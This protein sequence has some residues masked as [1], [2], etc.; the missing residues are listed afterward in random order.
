MLIQAVGV[1]IL[2]LGGT[3]APRGG[4]RLLH[5]WNTNARAFGHAAAEAVSESRQHGLP[6]GRHAHFIPGREGSL[7]NS[8][9]ADSR[10][11]TT[12]SDFPCHAARH[13]RENDD[14][15]EG[16]ARYPGYTYP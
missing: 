9:A 11:Q 3:L 1:P 15:R 16:Y 10:R 2:E 12:K 6:R 5:S 4:L 14:Y 7:S 8:R 13:H